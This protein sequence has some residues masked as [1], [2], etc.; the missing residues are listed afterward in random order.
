[1]LFASMFLVCGG[2]DWEAILDAR[3][4]QGTWVILSVERDGK[5]LAPPQW[6]YS[7]LMFDGNKARLEGAERCDE[8]TFELRSARAGTC[9]CDFA[10][11]SHKWKEGDGGKKLNCALW[12][13]ET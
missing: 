10:L 3:R 9:R 13:I 6:P 7:K 11:N 2:L 12:C 4:F 5:R 8:G 1:M